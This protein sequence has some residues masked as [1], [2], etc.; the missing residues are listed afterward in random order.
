MKI[1]GKDYKIRG[2]NKKYP[3]LDD[4]D[5]LYSLLKE[6]C[7]KDLADELGVGSGCISYRIDKYFPEEWKKNIKRKRR[8]H[9]KNVKKKILLQ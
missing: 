3:F 1:H 6:K 7:V 2:A 8:K 9:K 4:L 5:Y